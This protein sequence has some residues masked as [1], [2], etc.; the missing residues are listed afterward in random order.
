[1]GELKGSLNK[2]R[3]RAQSEQ[4]KG[5]SSQPA[6]LRGWAVPRACW[7]VGVPHWETAQPSPFVFP[8][9]YYG[10]LCSR[11]VGVNRGQTGLWSRSVARSNVY[12]SL[13]LPDLCLSG[14]SPVVEQEHLHPSVE[15]GEAESR[16]CEVEIGS[17]GECI[18]F[19]L[20]VR[21]TL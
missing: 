18:F 7:A 8:V 19:R 15:E 6:A 20:L 5:V 13:A 21:Q 1:M 9:S 16:M 14:F 3:V 17:A 10:E 12:C 2:L 4:R 11:C